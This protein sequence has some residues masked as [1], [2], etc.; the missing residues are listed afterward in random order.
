M[1]ASDRPE[2][3]D[4]RSDEDADRT[5]V[6]TDAAEDNADA[7]GSAAQRGES[8]SAAQTDAQRDGI[9][10]PPPWQRST[11]TAG[12]AATE[13][14]TDAGAADTAV[15]GETASAGDTA[16]LADTAGSPN[17]ATGSTG[18]VHDQDTVRTQLPGTE[19][20]RTSVS[21]NSGS[22]TG[23][24]AGG[25]TTARRPS[26]GP[27]R[28]SLNV[29]RVDPW[30]VLKLALVLSIALFIVWMIAVAVLYGV[31]DG[32]GVWDNLNSGISDLTQTE[33]TATEPLIGAAS[34]FGVALIVGAINI[35]LIT[36]LSTVAAFV[37]NV[38]ADFAG[39]LEVTL[40]ERE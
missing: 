9:E 11:A 3:S 21:F 28:A 7:A 25:T 38:A 29:K 37:Y 12:A 1:T 15:A 19:Q 33:D 2:G 24:G 30:S 16:G 23:G 20:Q 17:A 22:N 5:V 35:V 34:V 31:L 13:A 8:D 10:T 39:G 36:A 14:S 18:S 6:I 27:R 32:M 26:R 40:S 4:S